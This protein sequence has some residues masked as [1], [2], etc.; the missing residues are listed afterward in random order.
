MQWLIEVSYKP[1]FFDVLGNTTKKDI[2]DLGI[3]GIR[4]VKTA[5]LY[6]IEG[7]ITENEL[8]LLCE[9]LLTDKI[10]QQ[11]KI[12]ASCIAHSDG[13]R[14]EVSPQMGRMHRASTPYK[15]N[16]ERRT[17]VPA[18]SF[19]C[20]KLRGTNDEQVFIVQVWYKKGVTDAVADT[21][22]KGALDIGIK[23]IDSA[24]T[25]YEYTI[26]GDISCENIEKI[27]KGLLANKVVQEYVIQK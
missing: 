9:E 26:T 16:D 20:A 27:C 11:Y 2:E 22:K 6:H 7:K 3:S 1:D 18:S 4:K 12:R 13:H 24:K 25:G 15:T 21:V 14:S 8:K 10:T 19:A 23:G 5:Q 17:L